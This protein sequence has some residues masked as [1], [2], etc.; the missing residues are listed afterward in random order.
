M[1]RES[2]SQIPQC[3]NIDAIQKVPG[4]KAPSDRDNR[5]HSNPQSNPPASDSKM[6]GG[7]PRTQIILTAVEPD[8]YLSLTGG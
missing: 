3:S 5:G 8:L 7:L 6:G 2:P 4:G 1:D